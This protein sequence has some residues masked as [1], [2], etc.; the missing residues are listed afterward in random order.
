M[1]IIAKEVSE[2]NKTSLISIDSLVRPEMFMVEERAFPGI[3]HNRPD[4][5]VIDHESKTCMLVE[6]AIPFD[7]FL[8]DCYQSKFDKYLPLCQRIG[9]IGYNL[10]K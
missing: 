1:N 6:V 2:T 8:N 5:C 4:I 3:H 10:Y 7:V 9:D